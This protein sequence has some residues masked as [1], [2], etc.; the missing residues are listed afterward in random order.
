MNKSYASFNF[1]SRLNK[2]KKIEA[3]LRDFKK[4]ENLKMLDIGCGSGVVS[5]FLGKISK[6][7]WAVDVKDERI[8]KKGFKFKKVKDEKL[9]FKDDSFDIIIS[10]FVIE[11]L[12]DK[13]MHIKE[14][15]RVLKK[16]GICYLSAPNKWAVFEPHYSLPFLSYLPK[17]LADYY[18]KLATN[19]TGE[20]DIKPLSFSEYYT[21]FRKNNFNIINYTLKFAKHPEKYCIKHSFML[22]IV[23]NIPYAILSKMNFIIPTYAF[24][25]KK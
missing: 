2:A 3:V 22:N 16:E 7:V 4:L 24:V 25:L 13:N 15:K 6:Y 20:Y 10:N 1:A 18:V 12:N 14:I 23:K 19:W 17:M 5:S 9:P 21:L 8:I 11:H